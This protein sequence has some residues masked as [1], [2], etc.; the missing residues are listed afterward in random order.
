MNVLAAC[1]RSGRVRDAF[2]ALGHNAMSAD[3]EATDV[4]GPHHQGDVTPLLAKQ[5]DM[6]IAFPPC[7]DLSLVN[8]SYMEAKLADGRAQAAVDLWDKCWNANADKVCVENP[9]PWPGLLP[10]HTQVIQP[11]EFGHAYTKRTHLWLRG[12]PPLMPDFGGPTGDE[13]SWV[14]AHRSPR[15]RSA[16][17]IGLAHAMARQWGAEA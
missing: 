6:V 8:A 15:V 12:L 13:K 4:D 9:Q 10:Q 16:T 2:R 17:P 5:W 11:W 14:M 1:E 7:T 3:L